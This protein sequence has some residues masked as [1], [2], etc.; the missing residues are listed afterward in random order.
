MNTNHN[1]E[2]DIVYEQCGVTIYDASIVDGIA[3]YGDI[4]AADGNSG[5]YFCN[6][7]GVILQESE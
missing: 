2:H 1:E 4:I 7:C 5:H 6:D 3:T